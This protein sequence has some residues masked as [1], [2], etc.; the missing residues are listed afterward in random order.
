MAHFHGLR[1]RMNHLAGGV[2]AGATVVGATNKD[3]AKGNP[4]RFQNMQ[5]RIEGVVKQATR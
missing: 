4:K 1:F 2:L 5:R 3:I